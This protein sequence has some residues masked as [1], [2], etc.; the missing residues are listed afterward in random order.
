MNQINNKTYKNYTNKGGGGT[1]NRDFGLGG[2]DNV[3]ENKAGFSF[4]KLKKD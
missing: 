3:G 2:Y 1:Y 4:S